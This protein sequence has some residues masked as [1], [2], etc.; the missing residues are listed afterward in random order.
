MKFCM[1]L[2]TAGP[3]E[4]STAYWT[5]AAGV[6]VA[7]ENALVASYVI[8]TMLLMNFCFVQESQFEGRLTYLSDS[9]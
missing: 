3:N 1:T 6:D 8:A 7:I 9:W 4:R 2:Q 5:D